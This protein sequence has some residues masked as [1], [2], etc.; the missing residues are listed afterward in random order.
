M[1]RKSV[2]IIVPVYGDWASLEDCIKSLH[3]YVQSRHRVLLVNDCG[4]EA[5]KIEKNI[6]EAIKNLTNFS[7][8]R[9]SENLGFVKNCN[10][11][12]FELDTTNNDILLLNSDTKVTE[13]F[14][15]EL[16]AIFELDETIGV[17]SPRSNNAT[18]TTV[19]L[20]AAAQKGIEAEKSYTL[21]QILKTKLPP[22]STV[23]TAHGFCMLIRRELIKRYGLFDEI[24]GK[25]YG[26]EVDFCQ[27]LSKHGHKSAIANRAYVFH[28][29]ARSFSHETKNSL[30]EINNKIIW[31]RY[32]SY[33]QAVRDYMSEAV[34]HEEA[35]LPTKPGQ[36][37]RQVLK[38]SGSFRKI[39]RKV[40]SLGQ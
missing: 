30:L 14:L 18:I 28:L 33:R 24:F 1:P 10:H 27:R 20:S 4:P 3:K 21:F 22:Y 8:F 7:Y 37:L 5:D 23:P 13:G 31:E 2:S 39:V 26:E 40:R 12:V 19:P 35:V 38:K 36:N 11:A 32:P 15:D 25:G 9:N 17:V 6:K 16:Q 29:E 34:A